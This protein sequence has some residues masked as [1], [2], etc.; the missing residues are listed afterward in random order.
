MT[1]SSN[2]FFFSNQ[3]IYM[4]MLA[5]GIICQCAVS[6]YMAEWLEQCYIELYHF[7]KNSSATKH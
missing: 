5:H 3:L 4:Y 2:L 7:L 1:P 6:L